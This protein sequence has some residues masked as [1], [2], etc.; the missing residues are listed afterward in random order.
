MSAES[1]QFSSTWSLISGESWTRLP[2]SE[3]EGGVQESECESY[4]STI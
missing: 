3:V 1:R 2:N 4:M